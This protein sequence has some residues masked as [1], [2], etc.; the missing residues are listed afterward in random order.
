MWNVP[1]IEVMRFMKVS[2]ESFR[3]I[4]LLTILVDQQHLHFVLPRCLYHQALNHGTTLA[5]LCADPFWSH[6]LLDPLHDLV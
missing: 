5:Y 1:A 4:R 3:A 6:L 2:L